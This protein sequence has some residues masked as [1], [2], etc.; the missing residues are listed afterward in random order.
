[1]AD[2]LLSGHRIRI[3]TF[4][5]DLS[6]ES[7]AIEVGRRMTGDHV[8]E[9]LERVSQHR[10]TCPETIRVDNGSEFISKSLDWWAYWNGVTLDF[11]RPGKP[12]GNALIESFNGRLREECPRAADATGICGIRSPGIPTGSRLG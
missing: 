10:G 1:M 7:L 2:Q 12:T 8:V 5:D 3:L 6:R 11:S 9:A 4:V